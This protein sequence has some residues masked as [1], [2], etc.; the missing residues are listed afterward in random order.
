[1]RLFHNPPGRLRMTEDDR[2]YIEVR[3]VWASPLSY[4]GQ[5]L[6]LLDGKG[7]EILL[8]KDPEAELSPE[9]WQVLKEELYHRYLNGT[10]HKI[11]E[12]KS[13]FGSTYWTVV[14]DRG[15]REFVTVSLQ[16]N[17][18]WLKPGYLV[19]FDVDGNRFEIPDVDALDPVSKK[20]LHTTV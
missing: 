9:N 5:F 3:P 4:P 6:C 11:I 2:S 18:Q 15:R 14:T 12:A 16:E 13:E 19:I 8:V 20:L 1:M 7:K 10:I 17:A